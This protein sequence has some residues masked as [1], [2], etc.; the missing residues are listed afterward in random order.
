[1][2][3]ALAAAPQDSR[4]ADTHTMIVDPA[5]ATLQVK[6]NDDDSQPPVIFLDSSDRLTISF[7]ELADDRRYMRYELIHCNAFWRSDG[8]VD[9]EFLD[10]F[11]EGTVDDYQFSQ[12]TLVHYVNYRITIPNEQVRPTISGNYLLRIF[13]ESNRDNT[14]LQVRFCLVEPAMKASAEVSSRTD[15][16]RNE[17]HQQLTIAVDTE[18]TEVNNP[19]TDIFVTVEQNGRTDNSVTVSRP[20][21]IAGSQLIW[22][23]DRDLIFEAGNEYRRMEIVSTNYPGMHVERYTYADPIYHATLLTDLP[24]TDLPYSYDQT[25]F[26]RFR[27]REYNSTDPDTEADYIATHFAL[28]MPEQ[29]FD[30]FIDGDLTLRR[31][32]PE[33]RMVY[34]RATRR[35]EH[36]MLLKQGAYNYQYLAVPAGSMRGSAA[37]V[38]GN[39][40]QTANQYLIKVYQRR[41]GSRYDRLVAVTMATSGT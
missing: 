11:N 21:R 28:D 5:F 24:R 9:T 16:D 4:R 15:I 6:V 8:L 1:M 3:S 20:T 19:Y 17:S 37:P 26:G 18:G 40:Y 13:D 30:I 35:Y 31:F 7:D 22:E 33:S 34:N 32:S 41:P 23:H 14:L 10:G 29:P 27:I 12:A 39:R 36:T 25:Q 2:A 38:E